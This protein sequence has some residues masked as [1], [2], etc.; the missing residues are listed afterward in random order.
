MSAEELVAKIAEIKNAHDTK[1]EEI[2]NLTY[3]VDKKISEMLSLEKVYADLIFE[4]NKKN[5]EN[6]V[7]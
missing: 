7:R 5:K 4:L 6:V 1:K 2:K 3:L